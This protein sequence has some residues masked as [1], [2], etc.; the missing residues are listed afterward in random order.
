MITRRWFCFA[1]LGG[2]WLISS[3]YAHG[4]YGGPWTLGD[5]VV[6]GA[7]ARVVPGGA[8]S[9]SIYLRI[10]NTGASEAKLI[11]AESS[12][13]QS[14]M[15]HETKD[16]DGVASMR[17]L[18]DGLVVPE[19]GEVLFAPGG[20]HVMLVGVTKSTPGELLPLR[21]DFGAGRFID[22]EVPI[23]PLTSS[24]PDGDYNSSAGADSEAGGQSLHK[25]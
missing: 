24:A 4:E 25:H 7:W 1:S 2:P 9:G 11:A 17:H 13:A 18:D 14:A 12:A 19:Y 3:A 20:F 5:L 8:K 10:R 21:L 22:I 23:F 6:D 15:L 16:T